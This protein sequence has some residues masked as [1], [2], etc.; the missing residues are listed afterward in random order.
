VI[1]D[2]HDLIFTFTGVAVLTVI[3]CPVAV[4]AV[5]LLGS[6][7]GW[8]RRPRAWR[9]SVAQ[10]GLVYG[11]VPF[12]WMTMMPGSRA[13]EVSGSVSLVPLR[14][15]ETMDTGQVVGNLFILAALGFCVPMLS[16]RWASLPR[17]TALAAA[18]STPIE[19]T[20]YA[21]RLDRVTS[22]DDVL[23][24]TCGAAI[25]ALA[26]YPWWRQP[27]SAGQD[28]QL[29]RRA[30]HRHVAVDGPL[31]PVAERLRLHEYDEV[32]LESLG[33]LGRE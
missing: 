7:R 31:D 5:G 24:N 33:Q 20:Q 26:S 12:V 30:R 9:T 29:L 17:I 11:T 1:R 19:L 2:W 3:A 28:H 6:A 8:M 14:D 32:E 4:L 27:E 16:S 22:I 21:A 13:G 18:C 25:A 15:L 10:V 23:L